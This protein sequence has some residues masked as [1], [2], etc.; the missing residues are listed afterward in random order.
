MFREMNVIAAVAYAAENAATGGPVFWTDLTDAERKIEVGKV[1]GI[2]RGDE[3]VAHDVFTAVVRATL[4]GP[5]GD[6]HGELAL[7]EIAKLGDF[8]INSGLLSVE[9]AQK[10]GSIVGHAL[11]ALEQLATIKS[12]FVPLVEEVDEGEAEAA[13]TERDETLAALP[14]GN[15]SIQ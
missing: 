2:M 9:E 3:D 7:E 6:G 1:M 5:N 13:K 8:L 4:H 12:M 14:A 11:A 15:D 10:G